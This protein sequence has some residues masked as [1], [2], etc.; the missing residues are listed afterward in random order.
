VQKSRSVKSGVSRGRSGNRQHRDSEAKKPVVDV[1]DLL[2][3]VG[4]DDDDD[5]LSVGGEG[6][7]KAPY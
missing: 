3:S 6:L 5:D 2:G 7:G 1:D 4:L